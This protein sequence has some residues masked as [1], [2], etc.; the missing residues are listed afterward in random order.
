M[1]SSPKIGA[2]KD[3][4]DLTRLGDYFKRPIAQLYRGFVK[5]MLEQLR[6]RMRQRQTVKSA[7]N[8][9]AVTVF[10]AARVPAF[11]EH[12]G[13]ADTLQGRFELAT[14]HGSLVMRALKQRPGLEGVAQAF[15]NEFFAS[16]DDSFRR[17]G[18]GDP[19]IPRR[20]RRS[21]EAFY[22]HL[23]A[24]DSALQ[25]GPEALEAALSRN[26]YGGEEVAPGAV[27]AVARYVLQTVGRLN[28]NSREAWRRGEVSFPGF[29][30]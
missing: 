24:Y 26:L 29:E 15:A 2:R 20:V 12:A 1:I 11:Y 16:I 23:K 25:E 30:I 28:A 4:V 10:E 22:G 17:M 21:A 9:L 14:L 18:V 5:I 13:V 8:L 7:G 27:S 19:A 3:A 6:S